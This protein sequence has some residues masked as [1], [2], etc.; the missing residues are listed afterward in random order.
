MGKY[1]KSRLASILRP[2]ENKFFLLIVFS[3]AINIL[4]LVPTMYMLSVYDRAVAS[5]SEFTLLMITVLMVVLL[6]GLGLLV[7]ARS[8][9][10]QRIAAQ[11]QKALSDKTFDVSYK[12][13]VYSAGAYTGGQGLE[14]LNGVKRFITSNTILGLLDAPFTPI[15]IVVMFLIHLYV[16]LLAIIGLFFMVILNVFNEKHNAA[17]V[18]RADAAFGAASRYLESNFSNAEVLESMGLVK[19][20][21][22]RWKRDSDTSLAMQVCAGESAGALAAISSSF[23]LILQS[24]VLGTGAFLVINQEISPGMMIAGSILLGRALAPVEQLIGGWGGFISARTQFSRLVDLFERVPDAGTKTLLPPPMGNLRVE[25]AAIASPAS[26]DLIIKGVSFS[27]GQGSHLGVVGP[28]GAGKSTLARALLGLW[29]CMRGTIRLDGADIFQWDREDLGPYIGYLPQ[30]MELLDGS[31]SDNIARMG[32][33]KSE[34]VVEAAKLADVHDLILRL[35]RGYDTI[36]GS[37]SGVLS[38]GQ[39]QRIGLARAL[40]GNPKYVVLDEP[41]TNLDQ[42][43]ERALLNA[44]KRLKALGTTLI[45][46]SHNVRVLAHLD[47]IMVLSHG[48]LTNFG[49]AGKILAE[50]E[51]TDAREAT[52]ELTERKKPK[53]EPVEEEATGKGSGMGGAKE[54]DDE[55]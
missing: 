47:T 17:A 46:I 2:I 21:R 53:P 22:Q 9:M 3:C 35:P 49:Q 14:D 36:I 10:L 18:R 37:R 31:I 40:Y 19:A 7:W 11:F 54:P 5:R 8:S 25:K 16:G 33:W 55:N 48:Q 28:S 50:Y 4:M 23:R 39:L 13:S 41:S 20:I 38:G 30:D 42:A 15:F 51:K 1:R 45:V 34:D 27:L 24:L 43:G 6:I 44:I 29:P 52:A 32:E 12:M 26:Q